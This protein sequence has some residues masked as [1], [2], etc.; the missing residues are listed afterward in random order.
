MRVVHVTFVALDCA[1]CT[2]ETDMHV[3]CDTSR[4]DW[5]AAEMAVRHKKKLTSTQG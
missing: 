3:K 5:P 1:I 4:L 2:G